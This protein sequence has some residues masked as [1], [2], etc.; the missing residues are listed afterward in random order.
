MSL[1]LYTPAIQ[2]K[3]G[4]CPFPIGNSYTNGG[5]SMAMLDYRRVI[6]FWAHLVVSWRV[7]D[8]K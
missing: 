7:N 6:G 2:K 8:R 5:S 1:H 3:N 4:N